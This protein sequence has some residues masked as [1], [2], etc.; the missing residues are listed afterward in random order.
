MPSLI[1]LGVSATAATVK[2]L[3]SVPST[4]PSLTLNTS[5]TLHRSFVAPSDS[6]AVH[7]QTTSQ[8]QDS[9]YEPEIFQDMLPPRSGLV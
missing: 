5:T 1:T 8:E 4:S 7:G 3:T 9:K 6:D 2:P